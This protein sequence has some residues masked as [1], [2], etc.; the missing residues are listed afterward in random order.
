MKE[1]LKQYLL[2]TP[3][4]DYEQSDVKN[5]ADEITSNIDNQPITL[6]MTLYHHVRD[7]ISYNPYT[8]CTDPTTMSASHTLKA[9]TSYCIP[10]AV[11]LGAMARYKGI[12]SRLGL[13]DV[14]N[15][16]SSPQLVAWLKS[17]IF[18]MHGYIELYLE[19][20][21]V[22]AT[23]AFNHQLCT[24]MKVPPLEFDGRRDS[25]FQTYLKDGTQH[26][27]Y[28]KDYGTFPEVP[29][30]FILE[31]IA[32]A[33]PHLAQ[34]YKSRARECSLEKDRETNYRMVYCSD[35]KTQI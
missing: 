10:K 22:K 23:P 35:P 26:M 13:A 32:K 2:P 15:H 16:L 18:V 19:G 24:M 12:P 21:W 5:Y 28:L 6:A 31:N 25:Q 9:K 34:D 1:S 33:Y 29:A 8:F 27:E 30:E 17:D 4:F 11:L 14:K 20:K 7:D 3:F